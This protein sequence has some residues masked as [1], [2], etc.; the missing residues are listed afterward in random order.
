MTGRMAMTSP[1]GRLEDH[2]ALGDRLHRQDRDLGD[3]DDRHREV[4]AEPAGV[5]DGERRAAEVVDPELPD[6]SAGRDI[7]DGM[8]EPADAELV[9]VADDRDDEPVVDGDR[10]AHVDAPLCDETGV[11]PVRVEG[12]VAP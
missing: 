6:P 10:D 2:R 9:D 12:G 3:V 8:V 5:V 7:G 4:R 11:G 1:S